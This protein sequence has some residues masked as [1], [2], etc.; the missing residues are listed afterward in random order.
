MTAAMVTLPMKSVTAHA[1]VD[2]QAPM[3]LG[4]IG[5]PAQTAMIG[6]SA[7]RTETHEG[8]HC[9]CQDAASHGFL[10]FNLLRDDVFV[11]SATA[12]LPDAGR[13]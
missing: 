10:L 12:Q 2:V 9:Q 8:N 1:M 11:C 13:W 7:A 4:T 3:Q 5:S 6:A